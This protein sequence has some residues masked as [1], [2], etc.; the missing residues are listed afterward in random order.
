[1]YE[2]KD[3][4]AASDTP[5]KEGRDQWW[6]EKIPSQNAEAAVEWVDAEDPLF[7]L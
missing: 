5:W 4:L 6:S 1:M 7:L 2:N 3:A